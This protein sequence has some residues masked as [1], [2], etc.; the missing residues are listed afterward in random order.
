M[1]RNNDDAPRILFVCY[2][3]VARSQM[4]ES[5][6]NQYTCSH[7]ATSAAADLNAGTRYK[8]PAQDVITV[9]R[10]ENIDVSNNI[11][12]PV[13]AVMVKDADVIIVMCDMDDCPRFLSDSGKVRHI[14]IPDPHSISIDYTRIVREEIKKMVLELVHSD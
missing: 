1:H 4:A 14:P 5:F 8:H 2:G 12:K 3:N 10:E 7:R 9:M 11:V 13:N 6:Y